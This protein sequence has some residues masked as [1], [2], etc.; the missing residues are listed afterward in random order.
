MPNLKEI[1]DQVV[2]AVKGYVERA[3]GPVIERI[4]VLEGMVKAIPAGPKGERG[5]RGE[6]GDPGIDAKGER[7]EQGPK[8]DSGKSAYELAVER[9]FSG[10]EV[11]WLESLRGKDG[12]DGES[13]KGDS[14]E[15]GKDAD[16]EEV[17]AIAREEVEAVV[18]RIPHP[19]DGA[20][21]SSILVGDG[22]PLEPGG[23]G[24]V[25][26][27]VKTGDVYKFA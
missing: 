25:Y 26:V 12:K 23:A 11:Q 18:S 21:G 19:E 15:R 24:D 27:D 16:H 10:S 14:G 8:G 4:K 22:P 1:G 7:G 6:K 5:E 3:L 9:G 17:R 20:A 2:A 13:I